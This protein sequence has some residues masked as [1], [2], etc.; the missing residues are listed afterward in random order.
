MAIKDKI[1][2]LIGR[3]WRKRLDQLFHLLWAMIALY[4]IA[5]DPNWYMGGISGFLLGLPRETI[6]QWPIGHWEDT[7]LDLLFFTIGG[8][9]IGVLCG[10]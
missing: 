7:A 10:G 5:S 3:K 4:P 2:E 1:D 6:D 9:I 8:I